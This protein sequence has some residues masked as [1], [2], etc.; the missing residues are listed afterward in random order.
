MGEGHVQ[1]CPPDQKQVPLLP[2]VVTEVCNA[3]TGDQ[4]RPAT[5]ADRPLRQPVP[6]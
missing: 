5:V 1:W 3:R 4:C 6:A 2:R